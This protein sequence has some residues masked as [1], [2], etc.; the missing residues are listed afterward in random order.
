MLFLPPPFF[1]HLPVSQA[2]KYLS[3]ILFKIQNPMSFNLYQLSLWY[4]HSAL[5]LSMF[6]LLLKTKLAIKMSTYLSRYG[7]L[8]EHSSMTTK[9]IKLY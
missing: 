1:T 4:L 8:L 6:W 3:D 5:A 2:Q 9:L 7:F